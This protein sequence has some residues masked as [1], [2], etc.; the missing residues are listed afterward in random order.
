MLKK[1]RDITSH[2]GDALYGTPKYIPDSDYYF[3]NG[4]NLTN[5]LIE[6]KE[7]TNRVSIDEYENYKKINH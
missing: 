6:F 1:L 7:S 3:I 4:N 5:G 2:L